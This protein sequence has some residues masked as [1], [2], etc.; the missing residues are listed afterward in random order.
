MNNPKNRVGAANIAAQLRRDINKGILLK[1]DRLP[2]ERRLSESFG[3]ARGTVREALIKLMDEKYVE[4]RAGSGTFVT[5]DPADVVAAPVESANPLELIDARFALEPHIC[6]LAVLHGRRT[7]FDRLEKCCE[8]MEA[9]NIGTR[10]FSETDTEFHKILA[11]ST[12][13]TLLA[14][15]INQINSVRGQKEWTKMRNLTLN[16][17]IIEK[18]NQQHRN[19]LNALRGREPE[20]AANL[21]KDHLETAR[22]SLTRAAET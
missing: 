21:M 11:E 13:N 22:L 15:I 10:L 12:G 18:Y 2:S 14:W 7:D 3:V 5:H 8:Q 1:H 4:I 17:Q 19:I 6:R 9:P 16:E 20:P